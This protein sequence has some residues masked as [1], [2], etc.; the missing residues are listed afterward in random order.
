MLSPA[1]WVPQPTRSPG[2]AKA[3]WP[4]TQELLSAH[5]Q[6]APQETAALFESS[7]SDR[8]GDPPG[9]DV[10]R[11]TCLSDF[12]AGALYITMPEIPLSS[13]TEKELPAAKP[14]ELA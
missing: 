1:G 8:K 5:R 11:W 14:A 10:A 4:S 9:L 3:T 2:A 7:V 12:R 13:V 6:R